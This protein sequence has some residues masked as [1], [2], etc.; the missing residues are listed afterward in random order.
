MIY[1]YL[2]IAG[3]FLLIIGIGLAFKKLAKNSTSDYF[4]GGGKM[5]WW[6]VGSAAF[7]AQFSAWTFTGAAGKAFND[8]FAVAMVYLGSTFAYFCGWAFFA[9]RFR[10]MRV[11]TPSEGIKRRFGEQSELYYSWAI[12]I[13]SVFS[14]GLWLNALGV[15][16]SVFFEADIGLTIIL[17]GLT[18]LFVSVISGAWGV[19]ASDFVQTLIVAVV[20]V[21]CAVVALVEVGG[22]VELVRNFPSGF[23]MGPNMNYGLILFCTFLFFLPK[24]VITVMNMNESYRFLTAKD[25]INARKASLLAMVL[26]AVGSIVFF[27]PP[28][29]TASL[30]PDAGSAYAELGSKATDSVYLVFT[31]NVMP[32]GTVGLLV[33]G[34][35]AATMSCM[36]SALNKTAGIFVRSVYQPLLARRNRKVDD[37]RQLLVGKTV[38]FVSGILAICAALFFV[39]LR[40]LSLF[41]L[42]MSFS[43]MIQMPLFLPLILGLFVKKTPSWAPWATVAVGMGVSWLTAY[44]I[45]P[46]VFAGW[47]GIDDLT[48]R[49]ASELNLVLTIAGHL[50]ITSPFFLAT[51][52]FYREKKDRYREETQR[53]FLDLETPVLSEGGQS[54]LDRQQRNMLGTIVTIM[55]TGILFMTLI[56]NPAWG[57][58]LFVLCA[59]AI[60]FVGI[61]LK[62]SARN[63][64]SPQLE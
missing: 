27:I 38:S 60:L 20:S 25:T 11:D 12:I 32:V 50:F 54:E 5:L 47:L 53:F 57:R 59:A 58:L 39:S 44:V 21:A 15:F 9:H 64:V 55:G 19:V 8:G 45:T 14:A 16:V 22:P 28:W 40:D 34:L 26:M 48:R 18:V 30:Y 31:R 23:I 42:M 37:K 24:Q 51:R 2:V 61:S 3:Y 49:E 36:D 13:Y 43:T 10:Q 35:F 6:M 29:A 4:R 7:M 17:A 62:M 1:E 52:Y 33:A 46:D 41:Q 56:P 63:R